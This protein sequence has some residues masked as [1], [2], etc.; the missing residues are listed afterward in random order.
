MSV[1]IAVSPC[2]K[3]TDHLEHNM[4]MRPRQQGTRQQEV[5][6]T[7]H[8]RRQRFC[9]NGRDDLSPRAAAE[10]GGLFRNIATPLKQFVVAHGN[11]VRHCHAIHADVAP[12]GRSTPA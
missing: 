3:T 5:G 8:C 12:A 10:F 2:H 1:R 9:G 4:N 11:L 7:Q 6:V